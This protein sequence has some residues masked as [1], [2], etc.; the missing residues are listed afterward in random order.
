MF[1]VLQARGNQQTSKVSLIELLQSQ[2]DVLQEVFFKARQENRLLNHRK[3]SKGSEMKASDFLTLKA[4]IEQSDIKLATALKHF[5]DRQRELDAA[6]SVEQ[7]KLEKEVAL[8]EYRNTLNEFN[9]VRDVYLQQKRQAQELEVA[10]QVGS[11][12]HSELLKQLNDKKLTCQHLGV[13]I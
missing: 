12:R 5:Q 2:V 1:G 11:Q 6:R 10:I 13:Q 3:E 8:R 4:Q 7:D 9:H